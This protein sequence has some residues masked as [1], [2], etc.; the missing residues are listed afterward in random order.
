MHYYRHRSAIGTP[1]IVSECI[2]WPILIAILGAALGL[3]VIVL[4]SGCFLMRRLDARSRAHADKLPVW[5]KRAGARLAQLRPAIPDCIRFATRP[6]Q[7]TV[8]QMHI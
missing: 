7:E 4:L 5:P 1:R 2:S 8:T 3:L 6:E